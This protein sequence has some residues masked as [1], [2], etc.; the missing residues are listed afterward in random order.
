MLQILQG[1]RT[2]DPCVLGAITAVMGLRG[3]ESGPVVEWINVVYFCLLCCVYFS[4]F[5]CFS[6]PYRPFPASLPIPII[7]LHL[8]SVKKIRKKITTS[9]LGVL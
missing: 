6:S 7:F 8:T 4:V 9:L 5:T 1:F 2:L 3:E